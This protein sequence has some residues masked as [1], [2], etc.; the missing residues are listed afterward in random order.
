MSRKIRRCAIFVATGALVSLSAW[1]GVDGQIEGTVVDNQGIAVP[2]VK[3]QLRSQKG[4]VIKETE[5]DPAGNYSFFPVVFGDYDVTTQVDGFTPS[6]SSV[7]VGSGGNTEVPIALEPAITG[8]EMV[9]RVEAKRRSLHDSSS[10]SS[11]EI[12]HK[13]ITDLPEGTEASLPHLLETT[14]PGVVKGAF[15][16]TFIRGN[17]ANVQYQIDGVQLP[18]SVS[19]TFAE[20]FSVRNIDHME[21]ITG[22]LPAEY[23][24]RLAAVVNIVTRSGTETPNGS[25][26]LNYGSYNTF[27]PQA[28]Y[29]GSNKAGDWHYFL[30]ANYDRTDRGIETP[31]PSGTAYG[32]QQLQG[33]TDAVHDQSNGN[34]QFVKIDWL[35]DNTDKYSLVLYQNYNF[36]QIPNFPSSFSPSDAYFSANYADIFGNSNP[37][38]V[39]PWVPAFTNDT[40]SNQDAYA[41]L[42]WKHTFSEHSFLQVSPYWKYSKI[43]FSN[44][45][46]NDLAAALNPATFIPGSNPDSFSLDRHVNNFGLMADHTYRPNDRNLIKM[47]FQLLASQAND[48]YRVDTILAGNAYSPALLPTV[49]SGGGI[50]RGY[51]ED[52]YV[53]DD[54]TISKQW[55]LNAGVRWTGT[56][57]IFPEDHSD[58]NAV[59]PRIGLNFMPNDQTK[60]H[61]YYG[62]LFQPAP[63]EDLRTIFNATPGGTPSAFY[64]I[65]PETDNYFETGVAR[66]LGG[67]HVANLNVYYKL[68]TNMLDDT[69]LLNTAIATPYNYAHGYAYGLEFSI[70][71]QLN[72]N[73]SDFFN[74]SFDIAKGEDISGGSFAF[75]RSTLPP[76]DTYVYLDHVQ[77]HTANYGLTYSTD[78]VFG[79]VEGLYGS[80]LR[81][82]PNNTVSLPEHF[83]YDLTVGYRFTGDDWLAKWKVQADILNVFNNVYPI[84]IANG[85]NGSHY[86]ADRELFVRVSK[87][88]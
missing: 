79:T 8:K 14:T 54:L 23:G 34:N 74:Y 29:G 1:G 25:A 50:D 84:T 78:T 44:D 65:K 55:T 66:D 38:P 4:A 36:Y 83:T 49:A 59:Q 21:L 41:E 2:K 27:S 48:S 62:R 63:L 56:Q 42:V 85:F 13:E 68:A 57:F 22:G 53:Q 35:P 33:G 60:L 6:D 88:L 19:G 77:L 82:G 46:A 39:F 26:E 32:A 9:R 37:T 30:S 58:A 70:K 16:Q 72:R 47:G 7:H 80:G 45:P 17:H 15:N 71:G 75:N 43:R 28:M 40:Q 12:T 73:F 3:V 67:S 10:T 20:A 24:E 86:A 18:D 52:V 31:Q 11:T 69:Q 87:D 81:T 5:T 64:D 51:F 76:A 61:V